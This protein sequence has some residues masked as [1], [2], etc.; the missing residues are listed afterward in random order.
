MTA[1]ADQV[2]DVHKEA[3]IGIGGPGWW[4]FKHLGLRF[5]EKD[6]L[7]ATLA[8][9]GISS[10][11]V[12]RYVLENPSED[13]QREILELYAGPL[14]RKGWEL[15]ARTQRNGSRVNVYA[16][17]DEEHFGGI[18]VVV[19]EEDKMNV[20]KISGDLRPEMFAELNMRLPALGQGL[21][22]EE[23]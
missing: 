6:D 10:I 18:F 16:Q 12:S 23:D 2:D 13:R 14:R 15:L 5:V 11:Q 19:F 1:R 21:P 7:A 3:E 9:K 20:V 4:V 8:M 17:A 22:E